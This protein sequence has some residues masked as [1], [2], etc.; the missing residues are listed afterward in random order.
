MEVVVGLSASCPRS[1]GVA[2]PDITNR[3]ISGRD[4]LLFY[5]CQIS[6]VLTPLI[7]GSL[8]LGLSERG[9]SLICQTSQIG[10]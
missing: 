1:M 8:R 5:G 2:K 4:L 9:D 3:K 6:P 10:A 7:R